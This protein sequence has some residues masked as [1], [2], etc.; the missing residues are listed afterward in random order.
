M[1]YLGMRGDEQAAV[2]EHIYIALLD[3][4]MLYLGMRGD[5]Q[6]GVPEHEEHLA[7]AQVQTPVA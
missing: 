3:A 5:E 6:A 7:H 2:P 4:D 1:L